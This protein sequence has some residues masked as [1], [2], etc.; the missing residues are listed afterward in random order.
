MIVKCL[1]LLKLDLQVV[2]DYFPLVFLQDLKVNETLDS[3]KGSEHNQ[4]PHTHTV[5]PVLPALLE[6][7]RGLGLK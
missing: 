6:T 5:P 4:Q 3:G 2:G 7:E 1:F